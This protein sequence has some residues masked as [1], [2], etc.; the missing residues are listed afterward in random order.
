MIFYASISVCWN[1]TICRALIQTVW[2][3]D[4]NSER[5]F[6]KSWF[7]KNYAQRT[8]SLRNYPACIELK[9]K[10]LQQYKYMGKHF[11]DNSWNQD[12]E[13]YFPQKLKVCRGSVG[14]I[15][16]LLV[17]ASPLLKS[18][19]CVLEQNTIRCLVLVKP[20]KTCPCMTEKLL[21]GMK[22]YNSNKEISIKS[23]IGND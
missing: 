21:T 19:C 5:V 8:I 12:L 18:L 23:W 2:R 4:G 6:R 20:R 14:R 3:S 11:E 9:G 10:P 1:P 17:Q 15:E 22:K 7:W 13:T 16:G